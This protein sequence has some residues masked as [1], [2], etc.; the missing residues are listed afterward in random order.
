M[1][2]SSQNL[3]E[4]TKGLL[5]L[6]R[7]VVLKAIENV[8]RIRE[9]SFSGKHKEFVAFCESEFGL[10]ASTISKWETIGDGFYAHGYT[11][12]DFL[13]DGKYRDYEVVY[14]AAKLEGPPE[15]RLAKALT[16]SRSDFKADKRDEIGPHTPE[17]K[18]VCVVPGCWTPEETHP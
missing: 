6:A 5:D 1:E 3:I 8:W 15:E 17:Y 12:D 7:K 13:I 16:L 4:E 18:P 2:L 10:K 9:E 11:A 14:A